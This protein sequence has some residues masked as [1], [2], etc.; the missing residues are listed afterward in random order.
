MTRTRLVFVAGAAIAAATVAACSK[1]PPA[2][3]EV[4]TAKVVAAVKADVRQLVADFNAHDAPKAVSHD[5]PGMVGMFHGAPNVVGPD[6]DL[7]QTKQQMADPLA[8]VEVSNETVD[9]ADSGDLAVY[10]ATYAFTTTDPHTKKPAVEHGNWLI[11]YSQQPGG[12]W[13]I[14]WNVVSDTP[15]PAPAK[16]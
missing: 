11:G 15:A 14:I 2:E 12:A 3:P 1:T 5:A 16:G 6:A 8:K 7:A 10:R 4:D 13:K 9:V